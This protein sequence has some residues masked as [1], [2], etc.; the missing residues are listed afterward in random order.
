MPHLRQETR[1]FCKHVYHVYSFVSNASCLY[2]INFSVLFAPMLFFCGHAMSQI[3][4]FFSVFNSKIYS[5]LLAVAS[6]R[7][8]NSNSHTSFTLLFSSTVSLSH[9]CSYQMVSWPTNSS[10]FAQA[11]PIL[12][13]TWLCLVRYSLFASLMHPATRCSTVSECWTHILQLPSSV[14][15]LTSFHHLVPTISPN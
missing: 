2:F 6:F 11:T 8:W 7:R 1:I 5:C 13:I 3:Q 10:C 12:I 9:R 14:S 15:P 4:I